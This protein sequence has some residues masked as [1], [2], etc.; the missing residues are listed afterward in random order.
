VT[1]A[2][3]W[4]AV[5]MP[6]YGTPPIALDHGA[7]VRVW[8][9]DG[10]EY[11]DFVAGIAV[12]SL[13]H[14]HP[15]IVEAVSTQVGRIAHTSNLAIHE[16][17]VRLAE[18]LVE[19]LGVPARVFFTN[20]GAEA[21]E[22]A[23]KLARK[24]GR[25]LDPDGGRVE[26]VAAHSSFHGRTLGA[27]AITGNAAKREPFAPLPGPVTFVDYGDVDALR[28]AV[29]GRTAALF[30][31]PTLGEGGVVPAPAGY[32]AA[33]RAICDATGALLVVDEVQ[34]GI[35][36]TGHWF[37]SLAEGVRPDVITLAKGLGGGLPI[38]ACLGIGSAGEL[39]APGDH[40]STF[41]GNPVSCAAAL[42]VLSTI[43]DDHLLDNVKRVGEHLADELAGIDSPLV[44]GVRGSGLWRAVV[45][46]APRAAEVE[47]AARANGLL[48]NAVK[49][50]VIRLAPPLILTEPEV[51]EAVPLLRAAID[52]VAG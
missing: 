25:A 34:S 22:C 38:G 28:A 10:R 42:A 50:D 52:E 48:V 13:G 33:A 18:R 4:D 12:S 47:A 23:V 40:G 5:M 2:S 29:T 1:L 21:T 35:G 51:D 37:A 14:A 46:T 17:G 30:V 15:A 9:V 24:H 11:L 39:F 31:E 8:D 36:R 6:N 43:A 32:L 3:R 45:L 41:G 20:S 19:L 27:L 44:A 16:P 26:I 7:G 49:P